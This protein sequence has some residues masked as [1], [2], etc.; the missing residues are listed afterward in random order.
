MNGGF[1]MVFQG[2][3]MTRKEAREWVIKYLYSR[4][5]Q[6]QCEESL[7]DFLEHQALDQTEIEY[8]RSVVAGVEGNLQSI[9][10][11]IEKYLRSWT[12]SRIPKLDLAILRAAVFE[13]KYSEDIPTGVAI[14]EAVEIA[15]KYSTDDSYRFINGVLGAIAREDA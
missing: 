10:Q 2:G 4:T 9:D 15:K 12:T 8:M 14:N 3:Y 11:D 7:E 13:I 6:D 1:F 5:F